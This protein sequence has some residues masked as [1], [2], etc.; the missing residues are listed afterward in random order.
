[1][2]V[3]CTGAVCVCAVDPDCRFHAHLVHKRMTVPRPPD[4]P[5]AAHPEPPAVSAALAHA[6]RRY[7]RFNVTLIAVLMTIGFVVS[8]VLPMLAERFGSVRLA[9]FPLLFYVGAQ[10]AIL[11]YLAL[12]VVYIVLMQF[13]DARLQRAAGT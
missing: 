5:P 8:F 9:G 10:G 7:W 3:D 6:H 12:I 2:Q 11:V 4:S 1:V 13:A